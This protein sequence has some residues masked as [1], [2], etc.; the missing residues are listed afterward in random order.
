M[1]LVNSPKEKKNH[2]PFLVS[3]E[4]EGNYIYLYMVLNFEP[5]SIGQILD[6]EYRA[7]F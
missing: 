3:L 1:P 4:I 2:F 5:S 6:S 7:M